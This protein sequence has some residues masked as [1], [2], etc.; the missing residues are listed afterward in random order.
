MNR[1]GTGVE[2][3]LVTGLICVTAW[4]NKKKKFK[5]HFEWTTDIE[6]ILEWFDITVRKEIK[7]KQKI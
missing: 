5:I 7:N 4:N 2:V 6:I 1:F 3:S